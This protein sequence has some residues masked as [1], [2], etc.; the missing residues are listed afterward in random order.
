MGKIKKKLF[1]VYYSVTKK[2]IPIYKLYK[3]TTTKK[4]HQS[5]LCFLFLTGNYILKATHTHTHLLLKNVF[6]FCS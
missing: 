5:Q 4:N 1:V 6:F 3:N 2:K